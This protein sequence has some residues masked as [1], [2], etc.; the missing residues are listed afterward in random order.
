MMMRS[1]RNIYKVLVIVLV[2]LV[3]SPQVAKAQK[4][5]VSTNALTWL[6]LGTINAEGSMGIGEHFTLNAGFTANPWKLTTPTYVQLKNRQYGG[7]IGAKYWP[8]HV[9][10]EWWIGAKVQYKNFEQAGLLTSGLMEGAALG[11]GL[12]GGY[13]LMIGKHFNLDFGLGVW[14]GRLLE[15]R[16]YK[17]EVADNN[18]I[19]EEGPRNFIFMD[20][21][22]V[23][24]V[25]IF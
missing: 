14:G 17:T 23:S 15:Y 18:R 16:K 19:V 6:N 4:W 2:L 5:A 13:S 21:I 3:G 8:W 20:N 1:L 22:M 7:Y 11:A 10:S 25:Y 12:S 24:L 9:F